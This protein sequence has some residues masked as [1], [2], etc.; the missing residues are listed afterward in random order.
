MYR[1]FLF[2]FA[3]AAA[4]AFAMGIGAL[5]MGYTEEEVPLTNGYRTLYYSAGPFLLFGFVQLLMKQDSRKGIVISFLVGLASFL[6]MAAIAYSLYW[7]EHDPKVRQRQARMLENERV[8]LEH[9][10]EQRL[11]QCRLFAR[12][13]EGTPVLVIYDGDSG[14]FGPGIRKDLDASLATGS[15]D[16]IDIATLAS[17]SEPAFKELA[18][19]WVQLR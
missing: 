7:A 10:Q 8:I 16:S 11:K 14:S 18:S 1:K 15:L 12:T 6:F 9:C 3:A 4:L 2:V 17:P 5:Y 19:E 13:A